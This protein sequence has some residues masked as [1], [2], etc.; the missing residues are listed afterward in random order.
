MKTKFYGKKISSILTLLPETEYTF[1]DDMKYNN[2]SEKQ[3]RKLQK[4]M[5]YD[6]HRF[7]KPDTYLSKVAIY[8]LKSMLDK[9]QL[10][11]NDIS[12]IVV[13]TS[14]PDYLMPATSNLI[15]HGLEL[16]SNVYA[17]DIN[18]QCSGFIN[19]LLQSFMLLNNDHM[20]K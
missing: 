5:G 20:K 15:M 19:G 6:R 7:F 4:T 18:Q 14:T 1:E 17:I 3:N 13:S 10:D 12:A 9:K 16:P 8:G 11:K 2:L